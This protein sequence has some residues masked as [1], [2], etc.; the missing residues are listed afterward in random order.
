MSEFVENFK[1]LLIIF[2][3]CCNNVKFFS[4]GSCH[5]YLQTVWTFFNVIIT[6]IAMVKLPLLTEQITVSELSIGSIIVMLQMGSIEFQLLINIFESYRTER[7]TNEFWQQMNVVEALLKSLNVNT[8]IFTRK[9]KKKLYQIF[10]I[11]LIQT[12]IVEYFFISSVAHDRK[13]LK[14]YTL[15]LYFHFVSR[16]SE[17]YHVMYVLVYYQQLQMFKHLLDGMIG[18][19]LFRG[20]LLG[21]DLKSEI[22]L[23]K[24]LHTILLESSETMN[25]IFLFMTYFLTCRWLVQINSFF[26]WILS[27]R[28]YSS[29][30]CIA[31]ILSLSFYFIPLLCNIF[32]LYYYCE[33]CLE[34][35]RSYFI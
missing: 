18:R 12:I 26:Y 15:Y 3:L 32:L 23:A 31:C 30:D 28:L 29:I 27:C 21:R 35:V 13:L 11:L 6:M 7:A 33:Q 10:A 9:T 2:R 20:V 4:T 8:T 19:P 1:P 16:I 14:L 22:R 25:S 24:K 5:Q 34:L 17:M